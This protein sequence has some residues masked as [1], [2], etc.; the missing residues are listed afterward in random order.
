MTHV[1]MWEAPAEGPESEWG[2]QVSDDEYLV[3]PSRPTQGEETA[4]GELDR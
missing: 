1:A 2:P 3:P 4:D